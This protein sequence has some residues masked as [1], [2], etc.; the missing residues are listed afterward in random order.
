MDIAP[1][2]TFLLLSNP[3]LPSM[4]ILAPP[5]GVSGDK[6]PRSRKDYSCN[7]KSFYRTIPWGYSNGKSFH[8]TIPVA[9]IGVVGDM[10]GAVPTRESEGLGP[11]P[12][13]LRRATL[14]VPCATNVPCRFPQGD[15]AAAA[16]A[17]HA[18]QVLRLV[19]AGGATSCVPT[20]SATHVT[21]ATTCACSGCAARSG[22]AGRSTRVRQRSLWTR[23]C[24]N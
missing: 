3:S 1:Q 16:T 8:R 7:G 6:L 20:R 14:A 19:R 23:V 17:F 22:S 11:A 2:F 9:W 12:V 5:N 24:R 21:R 15:G 4:P 10:S 13:P 18:R